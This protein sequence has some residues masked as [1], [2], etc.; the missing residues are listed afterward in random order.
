MADNSEQHIVSNR[1]FCAHC[2]IENPKGDYACSR[3]GER[4]LE[5][6]ADTVAPLGLVS[7]SHC[8]SANNS[9]AAYCW[10]CGEEM[11]DAV[12]ISPTPRP[13]PAAAPAGR[14]R[15]APTAAPKARAYRPDLNP[16]STP[17]SE[18]SRDPSEPGDLRGSSSQSPDFDIQPASDFPIDDADL[19]PNTSGTKDGE[20]PPGVKK[21]NWAAFLM[22]AIWG[23]FSGVPYTIILFGAALLP[24]GVQFMV[25]LGASL[26]LGF[27]GNE[28]AWRGKKWSSVE[29]FNSFQKQWTSWAVKLTIAVGVLLIFWLMTQGSA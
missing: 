6:H 11:N 15:S 4:L 3:C 24:T 12:R 18:P 5:I 20:I 21:W 26:F 10:V 28:L 14:P 27:K 19:P 1:I 17:T 7:C 13:E 8:G 2:G 23:L 29:H 9:R 16:V 22:P 25:M